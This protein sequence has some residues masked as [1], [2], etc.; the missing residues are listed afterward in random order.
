[1]EILRRN[2]RQICCTHRSQ[3]NRRLDFRRS[4]R[5]RNISDLAA[6]PFDFQKGL[7][8]STGDGLF[9]RKMEER[10]LDMLCHATQDQCFENNPE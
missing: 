10:R 3:R 7:K 4:Y 8:I 6:L 1:M 9:A 5:V 2:F